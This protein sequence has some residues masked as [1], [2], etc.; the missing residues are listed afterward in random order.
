M[1]LSDQRGVVPI[2]T[3]ALVE[4]TEG[5]REGGDEH[6]GEETHEELTVHSIC[7]TSVAGDRGSNVLDVEG[8]LET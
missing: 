2:P 1:S 4:F 5:G 7:E 8:A 3:T 6:V